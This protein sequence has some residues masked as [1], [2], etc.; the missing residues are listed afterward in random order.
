MTDGKQISVAELL[1]RN[2]Q[3]NGG[4]NGGGRRRRAGKNGGVS[5]ASLT[6]EFPVVQDV[7]NPQPQPTTAAGAQP[8]AQSQPVS[9]PQPVSQPQ[10]VA[11]PQPAPPPVG[12]PAAAPQP[13]ALLLRQDVSPQAAPTPL[14]A[15]P[16]VQ[17]PVLPQPVSQPAPIV[18]QQ[19]D[20]AVPQQLS[21][22]TVTSRPAVFPVR[23]PTVGPTVPVLPY[24]FGAPAV[25]PVTPAP[26]V[27]AAAEK[28]TK[29]RTRAERRAAE[30][31]E[32]AEREAV[33]TAAPVSHVRAEVAETVDEQPAYNPQQDFPTAIN[34]P[35]ATGM[36]SPPAGQF[37]L[38][39]TSTPTPSPMI[40]PTPAV[41]EPGSVPAPE[42][43]AFAPVGQTYAP[44][45][46]A[47]ATAL[48]PAVGVGKTGVP[49]KLRSFPLGRFGAAAQRTEDAPTEIRQPDAKAG[50]GKDEPQQP[51][52]QQAASAAAATSVWPAPA[53]GM[54]GAGSLT[55]DESAPAGSPAGDTG[56]EP[57]S[58]KEKLRKPKKQAQRAAAAMDFPTAVWSVANQ[59]SALMAGPAL[60]DELMRQDAPPL[61]AGPSLAGELM[62][63]APEEPF[64]P[65]EYY[66]NPEPDDQPTDVDHPFF[67]RGV[68]YDE[69]RAVD[70]IDES[71]EDD[72]KIKRAWWIQVGQWL[73]AGVS[74]V[75]L[76]KG[77]EV[78][79]V[80]L[81]MVALALAVTVI[82]GLVAL[83]RILRRTDD[84]LSL[85][86]AVVVGVFVT[87]GPLAFTLRTG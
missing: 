5:V 43:A 3:Q 66:H 57:K 40:D 69:P 31:R 53:V 26:A 74:G 36:V 32:R 25:P 23:P 9:R 58:R 6:G 1:A 7:E 82:L 4:Q 71:A 54:A 87:L 39:P 41:L 56:Q 49:S 47:E 72:G 76:F 77:F 67:S 73:A 51:A 18:P 37:G 83:V 10:P 33:A 17:Q 55:A 27:E 2:G 24:S 50:K 65:T 11:L 13:P 15:Q 21:Q 52:P 29:R 79:W 14:A 44:P 48:N 63:G 80:H 35:A 59:E 8:V 75:L 28:P 78:L 22:P 62:R 70:D 46:D 61:L 81:A 34:Q 42:P 84:V 64:E 38:A 86:I 68:D 19:P 12:Q 16:V 20:A 30:E 45:T 60:A 85:A